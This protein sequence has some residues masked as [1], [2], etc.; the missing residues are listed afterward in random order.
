MCR[1][2]SVIKTDQFRLLSSKPRGL[3]INTLFKGTDNLP[4]DF[5]F[6]GIFKGTDNLP[7]DFTAEAADGSAVR[8]SELTKGK[9]VVFTVWSAGSGIPA[10]MLAFQD[11]WSRRYADQG[12]RFV[13]LG[14]YGSRED[15]DKWHAANA[16][17]LSFPVLFDPAGAAPRPAK[18]AMDE[19]NDEEMKAF[20]EAT[21]IYFG[22]VIPMAFSGGAV[23]PVPHNC[24]IDAQ[25]KF[26]GFYV[27]AG[28]QSAESLG[29][30]LLRA[31]VKLA[32]GDM[33]K[34]VFTAEET[35]EPG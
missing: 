10:E 15:F 25:G 7:R 32:P 31:G 1:W 11:D 33:P 13:A 17:K 8:F 35:K 5:I 9:T 6:K 16:T 21:R 19:M 12:V 3:R 18:A 14:A 28:P 4:R 20:R 27:G 2:S 24:V 22:K 30:L 34:K 29:N 26:I 23:A